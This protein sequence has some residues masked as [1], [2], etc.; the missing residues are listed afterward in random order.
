MLLQNKFIAFTE[1]LSLWYLFSLFD[2]VVSQNNTDLDL[3]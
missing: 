2:Q 3:D 1:Q